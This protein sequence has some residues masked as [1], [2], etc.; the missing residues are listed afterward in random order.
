MA[1]TRSEI[2][3]LYQKEVAPAIVSA[4]IEQMYNLL[5]NAQKNVVW[6][7]VKN[8]LTTEL[9]NDK[10]KLVDSRDASVAAHNEGIAI[11]DQ[12]LADVAASTP[13]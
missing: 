6:P 11:I 3:L 9:N 8:D 10:T 2:L 5:T 7:I 13:L 1:M 4:R 12:K